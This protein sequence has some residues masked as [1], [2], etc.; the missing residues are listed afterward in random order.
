VTTYPLS[1]EGVG[2]A[3]RTLDVESWEIAEKLRAAG[4]KGTPMDPCRCV[5]A[6]YIA[7]LL[8]CGTEVSV[9]A[10]Y[11]SFEGWTRTVDGFD[12]RAS[13]SRRLPDGAQDLV[14]EFDKGEYPDLI[15]GAAA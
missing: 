6:M 4:V 8:P 7:S 13:F 15:E 10:E 5:L 1:K 11:V 3:L 12:E 2:A 14:Q 9:E